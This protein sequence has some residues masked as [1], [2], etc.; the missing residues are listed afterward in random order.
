MVD[1]EPPAASRIND[2]NESD[3]PAVQVDLPIHAAAFYSPAA[4][5][6]DQPTTKPAEL[7]ALRASAVDAYFAD[8]LQELKEGFRFEPGEDF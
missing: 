8:D 2:R 5:E 7:D 4:V 6:D 1:T 3:T